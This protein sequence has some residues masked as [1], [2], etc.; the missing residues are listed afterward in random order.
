MNPFDEH[1]LPDELHEVAERLRAARP[2]FTELELDQLKLRAMTKSS[3]AKASIADRS[4][5][6]LMRSRVLTL[7]LTALLIGGTT[8]SGIASGG[9]KGGDAA[10][11]QYK[12]PCEDKNDKDQ[13]EDKNNK[14]KDKNDKDKDK[15]DRGDQGGHGGKGDQGG[16]GGNNGNGG[17]GAQGGNGGKGGKGK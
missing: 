10:K 8:A 15:C 6:T 2:T 4:R 9:D 17:K 3:G 7:A 11:A 5:G 1:D 14:G 16:K 13:G 12:P